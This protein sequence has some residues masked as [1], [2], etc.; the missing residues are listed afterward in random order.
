MRHNSILNGED[1]PFGLTGLSGNYEEEGGTMTQTQTKTGTVKWFNVEK[2][3]GFIA[4]EG[5]DKDVFVHHSDIMM[6]GYRSLIE[7]Q[8]VEFEYETS[9]RGFK[10]TKVKPA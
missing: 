2:G 7:G 6:E 4:C 5:F 9:D 8:A 1:N 3:Y 10:A